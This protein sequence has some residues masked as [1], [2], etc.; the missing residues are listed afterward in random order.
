MYSGGG[1]VFFCPPKG[2]YYLASHGYRYPN[3]LMRGQDGPIYV[4]SAVMGG[5]TVLKPQEDGTLRKVHQ[6][7]IDYPLDNISQDGNGD[8]WAA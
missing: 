2:A 4:P 8:I 3:G 5:I 7:K 6:I 1:D